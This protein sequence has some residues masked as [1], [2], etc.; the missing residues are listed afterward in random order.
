MR[1]V[2]VLSRAAVV[3]VVALPLFVAGVERRQVPQGDN[4]PVTRREFEG[5]MSE[6]DQRND[7]HFRLNDVAVTAALAAQ[8]R[9]LDALNEIRGSLKDQAATFVTRTELAHLDDAIRVLQVEQASAA[10][11]ATR[12]ILLMGVFFTVVQLGLAYWRGR[13]KV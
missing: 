10:G 1:L 5:R 2:P 3:A 9:R 4:T 11:A 12:T 13:P 6:L 7:L 8:D